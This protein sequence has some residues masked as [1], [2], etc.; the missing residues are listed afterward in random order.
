MEHARTHTLPV[1]RGTDAHTHTDRHTDTHTHNTHAHIDT[2]THAY[3]HHT[4]PDRGFVGQPET[5]I[6]NS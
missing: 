3:A 6:E 4:H 5:L 2:H 1:A